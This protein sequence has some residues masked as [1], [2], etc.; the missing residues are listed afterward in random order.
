[1][2]TAF[3]LSRL[4]HFR[5]HGT[6]TPT[7]AGYGKRIDGLPFQARAAG[8]GELGADFDFHGD[9]HPRDPTRAL[10]ELEASRRSLP[11]TVRSGFS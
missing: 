1:M 7:P 5:S 9:G 2:T 4:Y 3:P 10:R 6:P 8:D 11:Q